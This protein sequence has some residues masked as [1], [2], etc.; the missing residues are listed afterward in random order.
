MPH[1][2]S[3]GEPLSA[4]RRT[5]ACTRWGAAEVRL[6][7]VARV[8]V[9]Q[10]APVPEPST[11]ESAHAKAE[12]RL[13]EI[14]DDAI[15]VYN[16]MLAKP[17]GKLPRVRPEVVDE[18]R[19]NVRRCL[20]L[21]SRICQQQYGAPKVTTKFW[22]A[23]FG[24]VD[25]DDFRSGRQGP[26]NSHPTWKPGFEYLTRPAIMAEVFEKAMAHGE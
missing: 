23:Y 18:R 5:A 19:K 11:T 22:E 20:Q 26:S 15:A 4:I 7:P 17:N 9:M 21:A 8:E 2:P 14:T 3:K 12:R 24:E 25:K 1:D 10:P 6:P 13:R 16:R